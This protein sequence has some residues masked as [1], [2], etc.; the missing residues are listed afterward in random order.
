MI[1]YRRYY[2]EYEQYRWQQGI[3]AR[4]KPEE[5]RAEIAVRTGRFAR[6]FKKLRKNKWMVGGGVLCLGARTNCE[7]VGA[8]RAGFKGSVGVDLYPLGDSMIRADWHN[9]PFE[10]RSFENVFTNS[11][12]HCYNF[13]KLALEIS[14]VL[15]PGGIFV[16]E[17]HAGYAMLQSGKSLEKMINLHDFNSMFWDDTWDLIDELRSVGL[18]I[19]AQSNGDK[20]CAFAFKKEM[21]WMKC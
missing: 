6:T 4:I 13:L 17:T 18:W 21:E 15:I 20:M 12:D 1:H 11:L 19:F 10:D 16:F 5:L 7:V 9:L 2:R 3:K 14:R 8:I